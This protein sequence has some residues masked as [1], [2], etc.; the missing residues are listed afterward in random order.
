MII[1]QANLDFLF[2]Q[3]E[4]R[5]Q[6]ALLKTPTFWQRY[7]TEVPSGTRESHY[8][9]IARIPRLRKWVGER[10]VHNLASRGYVIV[11][12]PYEDTISISRPDVEDDQFGFFNMGTELLGMQTKLWPELQLVN[13]LQNGHTTGAAYQCFDGQPFFSASHPVNTDNAGQGTY[14]NY[15]ASGLALTAPNYQTARQ[16]MMGYKGEDGNPLAIIPDV[17]MVPPALETVGRQI[18]N[19]DFIAPAAALG[20]NATSVMQSNVLKGSADLVVNPHLAGQDTTWYLLCTQ[21]P[22]KP[23]IWQLRQAPRFVAKVSPDDETVFRLNEYQYGV[24]ARGNPG[25][26]LPFLAYKAAA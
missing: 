10:T 21:F 20:G 23:L 16:T 6:Q 5:F 25:F 17:L 14:S 24:D 9:W 13:M 26:S 1:N 11:N 19:A 15:S 7:A 12:E 8:G 3:A 2:W 22:I 18:L 4:F